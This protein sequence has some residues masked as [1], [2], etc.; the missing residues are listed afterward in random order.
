LDFKEN[1]VTE[2]EYIQIFQNWGWEYVVRYYN[3]LFSVRKMEKFEE[4][5][6]ILSDI[7][8]EN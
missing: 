2:E 5:R 3:G 7:E 6:L 4:N 8:Y 1:G